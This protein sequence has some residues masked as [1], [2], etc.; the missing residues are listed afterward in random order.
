MMK[1]IYDFIVIGAGP[2]GSFVSYMLAK[3]GLKVL[4]IDRHSVMPRKVCGEYLCPKGVSLLQSHGLGDRII[5]EFLP[6]KGMDIYT[7]QGTFVPT[8][9]PKKMMVPNHDTLMPCILN[10]GV[11]VRR[12][13]FDKNILDL[14]VVSGAVFKGGLS[15][16]SISMNSDKWVIETD[17]GSFMSNAVIG[18]DGRQSKVSKTFQ[19][20]LVSKNRRVALHCFVQN[21]NTNIRKGEMHLFEDG[22][23]IGI[24]PTSANELNFSLVLDAEYLKKWKNPVLALNNYIS[25]SK[26][27]SERFELLNLETKVHATFPISH[28]VKTV[29]PAYKV[30]LIGD[31]A[32]FVDPLTGEGMYNALYSAEILAFELINHLQKHL[33]LS[34]EPFERYNREYRKVLNA[35]SKLNKGFQWLIRRPKL[36]EVIARFILQK[37]K[38]A[39][40]FIGI[41]GNIYTPVEGFIK[42]FI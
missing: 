32:G 29:I 33:L 15:L 23:Y 41:V 34:N 21:R 11:A 13:V 24:D 36:V 18:A 3:K 26:N 22:S 7:S 28:E 14:A 5:G 16:K 19:N 10:G 8:E 1:H 38:R 42:L 25:Q 30:A 6:L 35:K 4:L 9:F 27:L 37:E 20:D 40:A 2:A 12:D 39:N 17:Q 31:A